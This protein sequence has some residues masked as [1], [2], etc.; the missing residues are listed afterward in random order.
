MRRK[1][2]ATTKKGE[3]KAKEPTDEPTRVPGGGY[4]LA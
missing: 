1:S 3:E 4:I 2:M